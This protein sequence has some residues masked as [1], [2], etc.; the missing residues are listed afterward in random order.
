MN[1]KVFWTAPFGYRENFLIMLGILFAGTVLQSAVGC[2]NVYLLHRPVNYYLFG[3]VCFICFC[4]SKGKNPVSQWVA[5]LPLAV[6]LIVVML[7]L[8]GI[9]GV[10]PQVQS[11]AAEDHSWVSRLGLTSVTK[12]WQFVL[13]YALLLFSLGTLAFKRLVKWNKK[14]I[15]FFMNHGGLFLVLLGAGLGTG[16]MQRF[17]MY[18]YERQVEWRVYSK[19]MDVLELPLAIQL[20][21]FD[22]EYYPPK[23]VLI[24]R[25]TGEV[26]PK[27][28]PE[29][30]Q[31][32][33]NGVQKGFLGDWQIN[34][35]TYYHKAVWAGNGEYKEN[36]MTGS[37]P[38]AK[39]TVTNRKTGQTK[40]G[41]VTA[42]NLSQFVSALY[43]DDST[44]CVMTKAEPKR[45]LSDIAV[46]TQDGQK[47]R[48]VL[49]VN[50]PLRIGSWTVYQ[51]G[52]DER[53]GNLSP[54]SSF[55][56]VY[57][58]WLY[59]VYAG[60]IMLCFGAFFMIWHGKKES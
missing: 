39:I 29:F 8:A 10:V 56:L 60:F 49:E 24:D 36:G 14:N 12:S 18:V 53:L 20:Y 51:Y 5:S 42:G 28:K 27:G 26:L 15:F 6:S 1:K 33:I 16:D 2:F 41:W 44:A 22:M 31:L 17:V 57:D 47:I 55:E 30:F 52:Y 9:M 48:T 25:K 59:V 7:F 58:P 37:S 3:I 54:Y 32:D 21:D 34:V 50:K 45:F 46:M 4:L 40:T 38:A 23:L 11:Q 19:K 43:L 13:C 35:L